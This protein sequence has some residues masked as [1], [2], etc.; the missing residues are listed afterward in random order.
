MGRRE[1]G[2]RSQQ[3]HEQEVGG[4]SVLYCVVPFLYLVPV[5]EKNPFLY[6]VPMSG[7]TS[8]CKLCCC[9]F[10]FMLKQ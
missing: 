8:S 3:V 7:L 1:D 2:Y 9:C 5:L 10:L 6:L 4:V